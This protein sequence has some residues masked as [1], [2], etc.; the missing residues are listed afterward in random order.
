ML[1]VGQEPKRKGDLRM[2]EITLT[3][4]KLN[5]SVAKAVSNILKEAPKDEECFGDFVIVHTIL[6]SMIAVELCK[7]L[8]GGGGESSDQ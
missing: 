3:E 5:K 6:G 8:F 7:I 1:L 2:K 4:D